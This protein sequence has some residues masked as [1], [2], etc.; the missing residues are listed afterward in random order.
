LFLFYAN[1]NKL[2]KR[3]IIK[4]NNLIKTK[5][6]TFP[7][8]AQHR[9]ISNYRLPLTK[10]IMLQARREDWQNCGYVVLALLE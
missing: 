8:N 4:K 10:T 7:R 6:R 2:K 5:N 1:K 9:N 3:I